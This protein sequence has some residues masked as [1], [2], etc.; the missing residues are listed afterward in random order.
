MPI[1]LLGHVVEF[2]LGPIFLALHLPELPAILGE[3]GQVVQLLA[4]GDLGALISAVVEGRLGLATRSLSSLLGTLV[5]VAVIGSLLGGGIGELGEL[6]G[7]G[8]LL[9][10]FG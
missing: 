10:L 9:E 1:D 4:A 2:A 6:G 3:Y 5:W 8:E 7:A